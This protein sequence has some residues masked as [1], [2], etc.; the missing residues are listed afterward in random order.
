MTGYPL[1]NRLGFTYYEFN[2]Q[3]CTHISIFEWIMN[4]KELH[5]VDYF[6]HKIYLTYQFSASAEFF[7]KRST[8]FISFSRMT[9]AHLAKHIQSSMNNELAFD[10]G[11]KNSQAVIPKFP[12]VLSQN[13]HS[14]LSKHCSGTVRILSQKSNP[15]RWIRTHW[16]QIHAR[17]ITF[18]ETHLKP[19]SSHSW[20]KKK[21]AKM[22]RAS[23]LMHAF[24]WNIHHRIKYF[25]I[26]CGH[27][28]HS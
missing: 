20:K 1:S 16:A 13:A 14:P 25:L 4:G 19:Y 22:S 17:S 2:I 18:L 12:I 27:K 23:Q 28:N 11:T 26:A 24:Q 21:K 6:I 9:I 8:V 3:S 10:R 7:P 5:L 15:F